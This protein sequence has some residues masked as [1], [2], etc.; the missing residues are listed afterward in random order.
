MRRRCSGRGPFGS[1][2]RRAEGAACWPRRPGRGGGAGLA[3]AALSAHGVSRA[4]STFPQ[5]WVL[6]RTARLAG[7]PPAPRRQRSP[8]PLQAP[9]PSWWGRP[10]PSAP[11]PGRAERSG[12]RWS[13]LCRGL[14]GASAAAVLGRAAGT[15]CEFGKSSLFLLGVLGIVRHSSSAPALEPG[16]CFLGKQC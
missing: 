6:S 4:T 14:P 9:H 16:F 3:A 7:S 5:A 13:E 10:E 15:V 12:W 11:M 1:G 2:G 8:G